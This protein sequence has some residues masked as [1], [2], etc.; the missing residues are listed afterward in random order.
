[1]PDS[2]QRRARLALVLVLLALSLWTI[3]DFLPALVWASVLAIAFWPFYQRMLRRFPP[4]RHN[5]VIPGLFAVG[6]GLLFGIPLVVLIIEGAREFHD[7]MELYR[8]ATTSG[9]PVPGWVGHLPFGA[10]AVSHWWQ[11]NLAGGLEPGSLTQ[12]INKGAI[13]RVGTTLAHQLA[14][15]TVLFFFALMTLFF[16]LKEGDTVVQQA[17]NA[18]GKLFGPRGER[19][20]RQM[21]ASVHGTV[22]G[23]VLVGLA[24]GL[25]MG[26]VYA[27]AGVS[28]PILFG[29]VTALAAM[30]PFAVTAVFLLVG[31]VLVVQGAVLAAAIVVVVGSVAA[32]LADHLVRPVLIGG[33]TRLPF[34]WVL[35]GILGGIETWGL[36]GLFIGP[37]LMAATILLWREFTDEGRPAAP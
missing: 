5:V 6:L 36:V 26:I 11:D 23:L 28:H 3:H 10:D 17:L 32:F 9:I 1:M 4:G 15:R 2:M 12:R 14:H 18:S 13:A 24:E 22:D 35:I 37:A 7:V 29:A 19:I 31:A 34:L 33:T 27:I 8:Q 21:V 20:A 30:V 25:F 16:L